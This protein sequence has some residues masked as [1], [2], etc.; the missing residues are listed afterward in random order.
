M[1]RKDTGALGE[2]L[3]ADFLRSRGYRI[4]ETNYRTRE[5]EIDIV[6]RDGECLVFVE[7]RSKRS[8]SF[9]SPE[10]SITPAKQNKLRLAAAHYLQSHDQL[11]Q[12]YRIDVLAIVFDR[13]NKPARIELFE[14]A[15]GE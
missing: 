6:A 5:G 1:K 8:L 10:E 9:G 15:V 3:A 14:N 12:P 7:V 13:S 11:T 2:R 4:V